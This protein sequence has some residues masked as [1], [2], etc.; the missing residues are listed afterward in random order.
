MNSFGNLF[1]PIKI[2]GM[3]VKNR[4][5]LPPM[6]TKLSTDKGEITDKLIEYYVNIARGGVGLITTEVADVEGTRRYNKLNIGLFDDLL[7]P[8]WKKLVDA[9]HKYDVRV[10][11]QLIH[12][13]PVPL[14][15][16]P[17]VSPG[18]L[19]PVAA[20]PVPHIYKLDV[21]PHELTIDEI[22][23]ITRLFRDAARRAKEVGCDGVEIHC[24]HN[25]GLLGSFV[26][27]LSNKRA[28]EYGGNLLNR[29]KFP[30]EIVKAIREENGPD[31]AIGARISG[32]NM[33]DGGLTIEDTCQMAKLFEAAGVDF[34]DVSNGTLHRPETILPCSGMPKALN[35]EY[36]R[37]IKQAVNVPVGSVGRINDPWTAD[38]LIV[39]DKADFVYMGRALISDP[40][41]PSKA[42]EGDTD[43]IRPCVGC[44]EC[45]S[46]VQYGGTF[47]KCTMNSSAGCEEK[48]ET[49]E[50]KKRILI[51]GGGPGGMEAARVATIR[52]HDVTIMEKTDRLGGQFIL[53]AFPPLKQEFAD[54]L[55]YKI[56]ELNKLGVM[57]ELNK[58]VTKQA[59]EEFAP[60]A[61]IVA[62]GGNPIMPGWLQ[63]SAHKKVISAWDALR[64]VKHPLGANV[65]VIGGGLVGCETADYLVSPHNIRPISGGR[66]VTIIEMQDNIMTDDSSSNRVLLVERLHRK[67]VNIITGAKVEEVLPDG[68]TYTSDGEKHS[69]KGIDT[70]IT[71]MGTL[72]ENSLYN[73]LSDLGIPV[74]LIG[75]A[76]K[77]SKIMNAIYEG[78]EAAKQL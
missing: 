2:N 4:I 7:I 14:Y 15:N 10:V 65:L 8:G 49:A 69:L 30:L 64:G 16:D 12:S 56:Q 61:V 47:F 74:M 57:V 45:V 76:N 42:K 51:V 22:H 40:E 68:I 21:I 39:T 70:I 59:V 75:D 67:N 66:K 78:A 55:R 26:T 46:S 43:D 28:D 23:G 44:C 29:M 38:D 72:P 1:S 77:P 36:S 32:C 50:L 17:K 63:N 6:G 34:F 19:G 18:Q 11:V 54:G 52:G 20:S 35:A 27:P 33:E 58:T 62:T 24:G 60:D 31:Y 41:L 48:L 25:H 71:A 37:R 9:L 73:E 53:A 13:G 5:F 3:T